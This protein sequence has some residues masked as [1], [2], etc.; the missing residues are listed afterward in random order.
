M[1]LYNIGGCIQ[2]R[3]KPLHTLFILSYSKHHLKTLNYNDM[4]PYRFLGTLKKFVRNKA[5]PEGS[6]AEAYI[7]YECVTFMSMY[8]EDIETRPNRKERN[9]CVDNGQ[10]GSELAIFNKNWRAISSSTYDWCN[11]IDL[12]IMHYTVLNN[13]QET[14]TYFE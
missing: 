10:G 7:D 5:R 13:C 14:Y 9:Y 6:I 3:G 8:L 2:L 4:I 12:A 1:D 11:P